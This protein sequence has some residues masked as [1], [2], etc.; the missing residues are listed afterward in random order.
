MLGMTIRSSNLSPND[1]KRSSNYEVKDVTFSLK[2]QKL[3]HADYTLDGTD[4][5]GF[6]NGSKLK[7]YYGPLTHKA[8]L[9]SWQRDVDAK[10]KAFKVRMA[11]LETDL[12]NTHSKLKQQGE[13]HPVATATLTI[14]MIPINDST[15]MAIVD[16][17]SS[18]LRRGNN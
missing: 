7:H 13:T 1:T 3:E 2:S 18:L 9:A 8:L 5:L 11:R 16:T 6:I 17:R 15:L 12:H 10:L 14:S 4:I